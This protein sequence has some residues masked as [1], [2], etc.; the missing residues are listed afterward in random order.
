[1]I[2]FWTENEFSIVKRL[3]ETVGTVDETGFDYDRFIPGD[4][5]EKE[6]V[7]NEGTVTWDLDGIGW[8]FECDHCDYVKENRR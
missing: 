1:M 8:T 3:S 5:V 2:D 6:C 4:Y 7:H